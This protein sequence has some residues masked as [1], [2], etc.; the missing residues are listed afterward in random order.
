MLARVTGIGYHIG[1]WRSARAS[2]VFGWLLVFAGAALFGCRDDEPKPSSSG[3]SPTEASTGADLQSAG[4][5][6]ASSTPAS[7]AVPEP[8]VMPEPRCR[9][10]MVKVTP[11]ESPAFCVDRY[12]ASL[13]DHAS[14]RELSPYYSPSR[15]RAVAAHDGWLGKRLEVGS[16]SARAMGLP[17][18]A[19]WRRSAE[20]SPRA[21][22]VR[23]VWPNG[24][25]TG[26]SAAEACA[27]AGKRLCTPTEWRVACGGEQGHRFPYGPT[28]VA[29]QCNVFREAHPAGVLHDDPSVGH[30]DPR[31][32]RV[33]VRGKPLLRK[34][35][36]TPNCA[37][38]WGDDA[39]YDMVG[40]LD[41]WVEH[42]RGSFAGGFYA[43]S[44]KDGCDWRSTAHSNGYADYSTG[45]RCC[46][47]MP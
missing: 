10:D 5:A 17:E 46:A 22:S 18:L 25:V 9:P 24:H 15:K 31:L 30:D 12:E 21:R 26:V 37:S 14:Q 47:D 45:V 44:S 2:F 8:S 28:Y 42:P 4:K 39:I 6:L 38:R 32:N 34:T 36:D 27:N 35:G 1:R 11:P 29:G 16:P 41:E 20:V 13:V 40:N 19:G 33:T 43:R 3:A 23:G 7:T